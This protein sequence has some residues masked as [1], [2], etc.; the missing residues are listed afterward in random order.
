[1]SLLFVSLTV[2]GAAVLL[3][4]ARINAASRA[5]ELETVRSRGASLWQLTALTLHSSLL[6]SFPRRW[7]ASAWRCSSR[8]LRGGVARA[9]LPGAQPVGVRR[10]QRTGTDS[11]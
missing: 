3:L 10:F 11:A 2:V 1:L 6:A 8:G 5:G 4:A 7:S 9:D